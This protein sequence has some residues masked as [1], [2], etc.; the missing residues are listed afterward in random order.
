VQGSEAW[1]K[2]RGKGLGS[3]DA[4]VLLGWS[5]WKTALELFEEK[6]G[7]YTPEFSEF[8]RS[9]MARGTRLE[10]VI[11][12]WYEQREGKLFTEA[13]ATHPE[14]EFMRASFDGRNTD[15][16]RVLEIK[17]PNG[18]DHGLALN[19]YVPEKYIPQ[20]QWLMMVGGHESCDYVSFGKNA[21]NFDTY[22]VVN[23]KRNAAIQAELK[24]RA[25]IFWEA[26]QAKGAIRPEDFERWDPTAEAR[27]PVVTATDEAIDACAREILAVE[28]QIKAL[29]GKSDA[30]REWLK[31]QLGDAPHRRTASAVFG[32][33]ERKGSIDYARV[34]ELA[35]LDL[36]QYRKAPTRSFY[37][38]QA[39]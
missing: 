9:A 29:E 6:M 27:D 23:V 10:P 5:P 20:V 24:R 31:A 21:D 26:V 34:P 16:D 4:A 33:Q 22:A 37:V 39:K 36:D 15:L 11:R 1:L 13:V 8:Q 7:R 38:K 2:W 32:W 25:L 19:G 28:A 18:K 3:S 17:A 30:A 12:R 14:H 35:G